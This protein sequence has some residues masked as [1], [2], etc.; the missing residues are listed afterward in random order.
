MPRPHDLSAALSR[1]PIADA[2]FAFVDVETTR[3]SPWSATAS[4]RSA[5]SVVRGR[6]RSA[7]SPYW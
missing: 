6:S 3:L 2:P 5:S 4:A 1:L 7:G